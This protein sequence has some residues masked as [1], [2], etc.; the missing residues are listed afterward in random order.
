[1]VACS[2]LAS[3]TKSR[4][5]I[6]VNVELCTKIIVILNN[7]QCVA[8]TFQLKICV[9]V[10]GINSLDNLQSLNSRKPGMRLFTETVL[11]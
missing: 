10:N 6:V 2:F 9:S 3:F 1:M 11:L 7:E 5:M 8:L 4:Y